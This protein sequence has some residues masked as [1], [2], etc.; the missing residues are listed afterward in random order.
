MPSGKEKQRPVHIA[1]VEAFAVAAGVA[2]DKVLRQA[3][4]GWMF[5][6]IYVYIRCCDGR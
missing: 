6:F 2:R 5:V 4:S 1:A 3:V